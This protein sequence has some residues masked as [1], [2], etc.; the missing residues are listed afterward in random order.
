MTVGTLSV[1]ELVFVRGSSNLTE[2]SKRTLDE[3]VQ[4]LQAWP[5]YYLIIKGNASQAGDMQDNK[6]LAEQRGEAAMKYLLGQ[7]IPT[8][9]MRVVTGEIT[10]QTRVTFMVGQ[11]PY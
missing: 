2:A 10:G 5:Q 7:G 8:D 1:P 4:K 11:T 9:R 3:L 6:A